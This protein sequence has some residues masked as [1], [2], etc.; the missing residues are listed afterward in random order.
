MKID[1]KRKLMEKTESVGIKRIIF[2]LVLLIFILYKFLFSSGFGMFEK[3]EKIIPN[4]GMASENIIESKDVSDTN[5]LKTKEKPSKITVYITGAVS[6]PGVFTLDSGKRLD[7]AIKM[8]GGVTNN[9]DL[10]RINLAM[11]IEDSQHYIIPKIGENTSVESTAQGENSSVQQANIASNSTNSSAKININS[12]D[13]KTLESIPGVGPS[14]SKKIVDY[15]NK[16]GKFNS[17]E[18]IKNVTGIGDKKFENMK[19][20]IDVK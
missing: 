19:E 17:I 18:D 9:A 4:Q 13:E 5:P 15:R 2:T 20:Y 8:A 6:N 11:N 14:T 12:A 7:D 16:E 3:K 10:N 1:I